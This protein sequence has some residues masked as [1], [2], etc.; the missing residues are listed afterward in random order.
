MKFLGHS[1]HQVLIVFPV[2]L[3][4][5]A[6]I[7]DLIALGTG[8]TQFWTVSYWLMASGVVGGLI[9]AVFGL[10]DWTHL[11]GH[12]RASRIGIM[13]GL[14]NV[15]VLLLFATSWW[16]RAAPGQPPASDVLALSFIGA[17]LL[18]VTGWLGGELVARLSVGVDEEANINASNSVR[19]HG[20]IEPT[21]SYRDAA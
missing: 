6:V 1:A 5:T 11:P 2:G 12:T 17:G 20:V 9:A 4:M 16:M 7:F 13:H 3:L 8:S 21:T 10:L 19:D 18:F 15:V 14:G